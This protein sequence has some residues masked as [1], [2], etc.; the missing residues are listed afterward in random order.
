[1]YEKRTC[2]TGREA[3][4]LGIHTAHFVGLSNPDGFLSHYLSLRILWPKQFFDSLK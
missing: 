2:L 3:W 1:M 4:E